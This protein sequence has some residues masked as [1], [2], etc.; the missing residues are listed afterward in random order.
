M[1]TPPGS[2]GKLSHQVLTEP[3][4]SGCLAV[5]SS[6]EWAIYSYHVTQRTRLYF[7]YRIHV[8]ESLVSIQF[9]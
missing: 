5:L 1:F 2:T 9:C 4:E 8:I 7:I 6:L 3:S